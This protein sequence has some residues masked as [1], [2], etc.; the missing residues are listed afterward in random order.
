MTGCIESGSS[1][2]YRQLDGTFEALVPALAKVLERAVSG[3]DVHTESD[4]RGHRL[5][6]PVRFPDGIGRGS[7][8]AQIFPYRDRV[9]IDI[10]LVHNRRLARSDGSPWRPPTA[11]RVRFRVPTGGRRRGSRPF[12]YLGVCGAGAIGTVTLAHDP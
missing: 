3:E 12:R 10:E 5:I 9:R 6:A 11:E 4:G 1:L 7:V 8:V 2:A